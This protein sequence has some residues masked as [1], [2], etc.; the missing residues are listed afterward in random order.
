MLDIIV[1][2][3]FLGLSETYGRRASSDAED[4]AQIRDERNQALYDAEQLRIDLEDT[5][6][7]L[8]RARKQCDEAC[9]QIQAYQLDHSRMTDAIHARDK[10]IS[11]VVMKATELDTLRQERDYHRREAARLQADLDRASQTAVRVVD[12]PLDDFKS[13]FDQVSEASI[14]S[15]SPNSVESINTAVDSILQDLLSEYDELLE[16][17]SDH[18]DN[19][20]KLVA[21]NHPIMEVLRGPLDAEYRGLLLD[22]LLHHLVMDH[23]QTM[24]FG[25]GVLSARLQPYES[26]LCMIHQTLRSRGAS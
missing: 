7:H 17:C 19:W 5:R 8:D 4:L 25:Y 12:T 22:A 16:K 21:V 15:N 6:K 2:T 1:P 11:E 14:H 24:F 13:T 10:A 23:L 9:G 18:A 20:R 26:V 3:R